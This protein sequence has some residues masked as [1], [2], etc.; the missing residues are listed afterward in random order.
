MKLIAT[1]LNKELIPFIHNVFE[2]NREILHGNIMTLDEWYIVFGEEADP[3]EANFVIMAD[4]VPAAWLKI[5]GLNKE[6]ISISMLVVD[7][8]FK[9]K[10]VGRFAIN[11]SEDYARKN[12]KSAI[13]IYTTKDNIIAKTCYL[14]CGY[15]ITHELVYKVGDGIDREG[16]EF[17]KIIV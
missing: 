6:T 2:Q 17:E 16:Y 4:S 12:N 3:Y 9:H 14:K 1:S 8:K 15:E 5:N 13:L 7:D 10:G 11:Y